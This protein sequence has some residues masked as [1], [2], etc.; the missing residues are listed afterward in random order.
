[1]FKPIFSIAKKL[2]STFKTKPK[3]ERFKIDMP[4]PREKAGVGRKRQKRVGLSP[5]DASQSSKKGSGSNE[6]HPTSPIQP[7]RR[8]RPLKAFYSSNRWR[9][10]SGMKPIKFRDGVQVSG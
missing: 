3:A 10:A 5:A 4:K 8:V 1:M 6:A 7:L 9:R 2:M